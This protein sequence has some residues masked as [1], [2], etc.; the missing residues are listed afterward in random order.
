AHG[1]PGF[2]PGKREY[3]PCP[4]CD[5]LGTTTTTIRPVTRVATY[6]PA[7]RYPGHY[8][9]SSTTTTK[10]PVTRFATYPPA[11]PTKRYTYRYG[12]SSTTTTRR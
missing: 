3:P 10:R 11:T 7:P 4:I 1:R 2:R 5:T 8:R 9:D 6:P 12:D